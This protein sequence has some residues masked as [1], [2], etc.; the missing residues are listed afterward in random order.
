MNN[1]L[2]LLQAEAVRGDDGIRR[3]VPGAAVPEA[4]HMQLEQL[5]A[6]H[7]RPV[8]G[9]RHSAEPVAQLGRAGDAGR[10]EAEPQP[11]LGVL[12]L[13]DRERWDVADANFSQYTTSTS[14]TTL[15]TTATPATFSYDPSGTTSAIPVRLGRFRSRRGSGW[16]DISTCWR[17]CCA[18]PAAKVL[19]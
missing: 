17:C 5:S 9:Q 12:A 3:A 15:S 11:P 13:G 8:E 10:I 7:H 4:L 2:S 6:A 19:P 18:T 1:T 16:R 14:T